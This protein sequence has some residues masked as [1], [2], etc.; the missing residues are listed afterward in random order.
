MRKSEVPGKLPENS[1]GF[2]TSLLA[3]VYYAKF[4]NLEL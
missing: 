2:F 3:E 4:G 1:G